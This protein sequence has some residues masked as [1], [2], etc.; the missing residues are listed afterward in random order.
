M[1]G[2]GLGNQAAD[3][4]SA[5]SALG[6]DT[7]GVGDTTP[8]GDVVETVVYYGSRST[9]TEAAAET[10]A[11]SMTG[12]VVVAYDPSQVTDGAQVTVVTG[13]QFAVNSATNPATTPTTSAA[14]ATIASPTPTTSNLEPWDPRAC[15]AGASPTAPAPNPT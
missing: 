8:V 14:A 15:P 7:V 12:S 4:A 11:H 6:F 10:V 13:T 5:L 1:N 3:T 9:T 2:T